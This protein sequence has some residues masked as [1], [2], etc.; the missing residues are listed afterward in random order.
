MQDCI[1]NIYKQAKN[2]INITVDLEI[3]SDYLLCPTADGVEMISE[4]SVRLAAKA[5]SVSS[6]IQADGSKGGNQFESTEFLPRDDGMETVSF[7]ELWPQ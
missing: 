7:G 1:P 5:Y 2:F 4:G 3:M 6:D